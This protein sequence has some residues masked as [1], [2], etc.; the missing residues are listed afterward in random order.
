MYETRRKQWGYSPYQ[1]ASRISEPSTAG[2]CESFAG[3][4]ESTG[5]RRSKSFEF[6]PCYPPVVSWRAF[7]QFHAVFFKR[8]CHG[9]LKFGASC[10]T[11]PEPRITPF[12]AMTLKT[13]SFQVGSNIYG[14]IMT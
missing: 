6:H 3:A 2:L 1:L 8:E 11:R 9:K 10:Y 5:F 13:S 14:E 4:F 12:E 7:F